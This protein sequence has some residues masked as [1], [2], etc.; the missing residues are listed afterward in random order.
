NSSYYW[1]SANVVNHVTGLNDPGEDINMIWGIPPVGPG[2]VGGSVLAGANKGTADGDPVVGLGIYLVNT[3]TSAVQGYT[4]TDAS[5]NYSFASV[6]LGT[7]QVFPEELNYTTIPYN[8]ITLTSASTSMATAKFRQRTVSKI[9]QPVTSGVEN[10]NANTFIT[11]FPNPTSGKLNIT[12]ENA[13][14]EVASIV[15]S[16][17]TGRQVVG[18]G[19]SMTKGNGAEV[20]D[21]SSL[22]NSVYFVTVK[23]ANVMYVNKIEVR[24]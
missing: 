9:I 19:F 10:V 21:L 2:F 7:Y 6:P 17:V 3:T 13:N 22:S 8:G 24:H 20:V 18:K 15:I 5:G 11:A 14:S 23:T 4:T 16:D 12:W 1:H